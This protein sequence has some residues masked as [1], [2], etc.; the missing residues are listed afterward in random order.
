MAQVVEHLP[1]K[2]NALSSNCSSGKE[3]RRKEEGRE[4]EGRKKGRRKEGRK[5]GRKVRA[6]SA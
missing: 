4:K 3:G 1:S 5:E 6:A 2:H